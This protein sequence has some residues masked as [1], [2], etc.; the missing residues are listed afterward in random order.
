MLDLDTGETM[1]PPATRRPEQERMDVHPNQVQPYHY[2]T[3]LV[4]LGLRGL[5]VKASDWNASDAEVLRALAE[6]NA[7]PLKEMDPGP[8]ERPTY[9]FRTR[10]GACGVLQL[11]EIVDEPKGMRIRYRRVKKGGSGRPLT[12]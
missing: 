11:L 4:G 9:F 3:A 5:E 6:K 12:E 8:E 2:P 10:D 7:Q 1:D